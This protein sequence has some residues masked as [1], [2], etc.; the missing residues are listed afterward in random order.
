MDPPEP[1]LR[2][3]FLTKER[4]HE[5]KTNFSGGRRGKSSPRDPGSTGTTWVRGDDGFRCR[6]GAHVIGSVALCTAPDRCTHAPKVGARIAPRGPQ[7]L[8]GY[9]CDHSHRF[10]H[11]GKRRGSH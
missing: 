8:S 1:G 4:L 6:P 11:G 2:S 3:V 7:A 9:A 10:W 5:S